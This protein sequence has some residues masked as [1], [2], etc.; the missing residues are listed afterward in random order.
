MPVGTSALERRVRSMTEAQRTDFYRL[1]MPRMVPQYARHTPHPKQQLFLA[2]NHVHEVMFGGSAGGGKSDAL[3]MSA[4]QYVDVPGYSALILRRTWPDLNSAGAILDRA[5][6]WLRG[7]DAIERDGGRYFLFPSGARLSFG[8]MQHENEK[9]KWQSAEFQFC[10]EQATPILMADGSWKPISKLV[11]GMFV[12]TLEGSRRI[13][14]VIAV[15]SKP[16]VRVTTRYGSA[17]VS[18]SHPILTPSGW[19][20]PVERLS[21]RSHAVD[22]TVEAFSSSYSAAQPLRAYSQPDQ[23]QAGALLERTHRRTGRL[24]T[25]AWPTDARSDCAE[26]VLT[27]RAGQRPQQWSFPATLYALDDPST[28]HEQHRHAHACVPASVIFDPSAQDFCACCQACCDCD[29]G[30]SRP[31]VAVAQLSLPSPDDAVQ[32]YLLNFGSDDLENTH[33]GS[34]IDS[35]LYAHPYTNETR[36]ASEAVRQDRVTVAPVGE[37]MMFDLEIDEVS[38]Y[39]SWSG[40]ISRNCAFDELTQFPESMYEYLHS[41]LRRPQLPCLTCGRPVKKYGTVYRHL[42]Q[43]RVR[44]SESRPVCNN[45]FPDPQMLEQYRPAADGMTLW[46]VPLRMRSASNPGGVGHEWVFRRFVDDA[47][48]DARSIFV[49]SSLMDNPSLDQD[50]YVEALSHLSGIEKERLLNGD[51]SAFEQGNIFQRS[52][53]TI[54]DEPSKDPN[55][56]RCRYWDMAASEGYGDWTVGTLVALVNGQWIVE[57]QVRGQ[58]GPSETE[59]IIRQTALSDGQEVVVRM[60]QEPGSSG[61]TVIDSY[62]RNILPGFNFDSDRPTGSKVARATPVAVSAENN[63]VKLVAGQWNKRLIDELEL[64]PLGSF[65]DQVD[66]LAGAFNV[67]AYSTPHVRIIV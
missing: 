48:K 34:R 46:D 25:Y 29:G 6:Q 5:R 7:T 31:G 59:T 52:W 47:S 64:F 54:I 13:K 3:L 14:R 65:D 38:H 42:A 39:V 23:Q 45:I 17:V 1:L 30:R 61:K 18:E 51:W 63:N 9:Y 15:G 40:I 16:A 44:S 8:Y 49:P 36:L 55:A 4:L 60:E 26:S 28:S 50:S 58:W 35:L 41:R 56:R 10:V 21:R 32:Q 33:T 12:Q 2:L 22:S 24:E 20:S 66:S 62:R 53:F 57:H 43:N 11:P 19:A 67:I 37:A 27:H